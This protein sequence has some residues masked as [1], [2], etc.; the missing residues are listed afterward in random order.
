M[1]DRA[2]WNTLMGVALTGAAFG[3]AWFD[4]RERR[5]PNAL[6]VGAFTTAILLRIPLGLDALGTG[7][8]GAVLA[9]GLAL[10]FFLVGGLGGG[11]VKL[12]VAVGAFL[13]PRN[14]WFALLVMAL[15]G[16]VMAV[17]VITKHRAFGQTAANLRSLFSTMGTG[18]FTGWKG[19]GSKATITL[20]T[21]GVLTV[22]YGVA[23]AAGALTSWLVYSANPEWS[24]TAMLQGWLA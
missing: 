5:L 12:L 13:G 6:T 11:D 16:G 23:I 18:T 7:F 19:E 9:F 22:P 3:A 24:L 2:M 15:V 1:N 21:P 10:P 20:D 4:V 17:F 14:L 8:L